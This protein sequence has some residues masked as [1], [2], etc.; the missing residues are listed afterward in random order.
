LPDEQ[1]S[2][3]GTNALNVAGTGECAFLLRSLQNDDE[4]EEARI[5]AEQTRRRLELMMIRWS[6]ASMVDGYKTWK[7]FALVP[8]SKISRL[9]QIVSHPPLALTF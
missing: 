1:I 4:E 8:E 2:S 7:E 6:K 3:Y 5:K 9:A